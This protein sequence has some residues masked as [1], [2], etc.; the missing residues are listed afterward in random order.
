[1][2][3][4]TNQKSMISN[5]TTTIRKINRMPA[6]EGEQI[7]YYEDN[8]NHNVFLDSWGKHPLFCKDCHV[9]QRCDLEGP[10]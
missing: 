9:Q 1:M 2:D 5:A 7:D 6:E 3:Y 10:S 8:N 4:L